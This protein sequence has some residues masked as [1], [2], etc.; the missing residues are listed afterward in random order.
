M[1]NRI[2][3]TAALT[4]AATIATGTVALATT[5]TDPGAPVGTDAAVSLARPASEPAPATATVPSTP[6]P[7]F[8]PQAVALLAFA[9]QME[10]RA[11]GS[12]PTSAA[13]P[14]TSAS[15]AA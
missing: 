8:D 5:L 15:P 9:D 2:A 6:T 4:L 13:R 14:A 11:T 1:P 7:A 3:V 10:Q 12:N